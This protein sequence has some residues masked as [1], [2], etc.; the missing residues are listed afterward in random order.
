MIMKNSKHY[1]KGISEEEMRLIL[2]DAQEF[3]PKQVENLG[4]FSASGIIS[5]FFR[6]NLPGKQLG[7]RTFIFYR[8]DLDNFLTEKIKTKER[9]RARSEKEE[10]NEGFYLIKIPISTF[11]FIKNF[12]NMNEVQVLN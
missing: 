3:T 12:I 10:R 4:L 8:H 2:G 7:A 11:D 9:T 1:L 5:N 6:G